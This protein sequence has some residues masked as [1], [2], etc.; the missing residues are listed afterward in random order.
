LLIERLLGSNRSKLLMVA[1]GNLDDARTKAQE[2]ADRND[3][4]LN[5]YREAGCPSTKLH[6]V[7]DLGT[8]EARERRSRTP[9]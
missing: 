2:K 9:Q 5:R 1:R 8:S 3:D 7:P 4:E 6:P